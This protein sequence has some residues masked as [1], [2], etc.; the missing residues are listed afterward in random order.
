MPTDDSFRELRQVYYT[1]CSAC[2]GT[3]GKGT[4]GLNARDFTDSAWQ[5][6]LTDDEIRE[7][8]ERGHVPL[9]P[10]FADSLDEETV[11]RLVK[12]VR[13]FGTAETDEQERK[14]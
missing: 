2:H 13:Q 3:D 1:K 4:P 14:P 12:L 9:M 11:Q 5:T 6:S 10:P 7:T 8:I